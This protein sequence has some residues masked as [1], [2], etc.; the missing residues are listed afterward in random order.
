MSE[1]LEDVVKPLTAPAP[2]RP[3]LQFVVDADALLNGSE[4]WGK[5]DL[6]LGIVALSSEEEIEAA[7][8]ARGDQMSMSYE[9]VKMAIVRVRP[10][11]EQWRDVDRGVM[12]QETIWHRLGPAGRNIAM[13]AFREV[14]AATVG[15][16]QKL[17]AS[18]RWA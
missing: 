16:V 5:G 10:P 3:V 7:K 8:R 1:D 17:R 18:F 9:F 11:G 12:E 14:G 6:E 2:K 13:I 4:W 15:A